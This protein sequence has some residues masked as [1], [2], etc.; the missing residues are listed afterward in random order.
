MVAQQTDAAVV[1]KREDGDGAGVDDNVA[2]DCAA[3]GPGLTSTAT[4]I[5][6]PVCTIVRAMTP[7]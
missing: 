7:P 6:R 3:A 5:L 2:R 1:G 4:W